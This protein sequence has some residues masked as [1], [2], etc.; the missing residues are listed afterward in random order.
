MRAWDCVKNVEFELFDAL[1]SALE[2]QD[3]RHCVRADVGAVAIFVFDHALLGMEDDDS[4][5]DEFLGDG[6][7]DNDGA[8]VAGDWDEFRFFGFFDGFTPN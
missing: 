7:F 4:A 8:A 3:C 1:L 5:G 2:G 6:V